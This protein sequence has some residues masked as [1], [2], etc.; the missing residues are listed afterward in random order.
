MQAL[1]FKSQ[2]IFG[3]CMKATPLSIFAA[4]AEIS[5]MGI[6]ELK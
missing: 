3:C 5:G 2:Q 1:D 6:K 4:M